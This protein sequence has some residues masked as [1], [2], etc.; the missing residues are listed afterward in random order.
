EIRH[1]LEVSAQVIAVERSVDALPSERLCVDFASQGLHHL[2]AHLLPLE[3]DPAG[4]IFIDGVDST[5]GLFGTTRPQKTMRNFGRHPW[6]GLGL[7]ALLSDEAIHVALSV[8]NFLQGQADCALALARSG[9]VGIERTAGAPPDHL[10][11]L[12]LG[13]FYGCLCQ[14]EKSYFP[15]PK[16][17]RSQRRGEDPNEAVILSI[18]ILVQGIEGALGKDFWGNLRH[19][20]DLTKVPACSMEDADHRSATVITAFEN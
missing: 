8:C 13:P 4:P 16:T 1:S 9:L 11:I 3:R 6:H 14:F 10:T 2:K 5:P 19:L 12:V 18:V 17:S 7:V 20:S 15:L